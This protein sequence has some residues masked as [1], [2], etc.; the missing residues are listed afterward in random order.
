MG[1]INELILLDYTQLN[2]LIKTS[3][4]SCMISIRHTC[5]YSLLEHFQ[6]ILKYWVYKIQMW[7][8]VFL[9]CSRFVLKGW[10]AYELL[11]EVERC[12]CGLSIFLYKM[13]FLCFM[14]FPSFFRF[15][16]ISLFSILKKIESIFG[17]QGL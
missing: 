7:S 9:Y 3:L 14:M 12:P 17:A 4:Q 10:Q 2:R 8:F 5:Q 11:C 13:I 15:F 1:F 16:C 6:M